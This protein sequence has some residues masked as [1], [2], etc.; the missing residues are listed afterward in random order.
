MVVSARA[1]PRI[2][3]RLRRLA[4]TH[5]VCLL[6]RKGP[7]QT[8]QAAPLLRIALSLGT[9]TIALHLCPAALSAGTHDQSFGRIV[10]QSG[11]DDSCPLGRRP[12][13]MGD[14]REGASKSGQPAL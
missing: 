2:R 4:C 5:A 7:A 13:G 12:A 8:D 6:G 11:P 1:R 9:A 10:L 3:A 14:R